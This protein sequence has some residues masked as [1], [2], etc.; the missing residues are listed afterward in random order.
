MMEDGPPNQQLTSTTAPGKVFA[1]R[2]DVAA[3]NKSDYHKY[4]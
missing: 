3:H 1:S 4:I 2:A